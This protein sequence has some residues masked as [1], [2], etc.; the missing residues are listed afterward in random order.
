MVMAIGTKFFLFTF[1]EWFV[2]TL[3]I[4][5]DF[6]MTLVQLARVYYRIQGAGIGQVAKQQNSGSC[7]ERRETPTVQSLRHS[8]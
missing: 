8:R 3:A 7:Y 4:F 6:G 2:A 1:V 5:F